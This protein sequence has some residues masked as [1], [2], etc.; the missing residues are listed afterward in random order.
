MSRAALSKAKLVDAGLKAAR[1]LL[2]VDRRHEFG[3]GYSVSLDDVNACALA[4][5]IVQQEVRKYVRGLP[6][7]RRNQRTP[8]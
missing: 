4:L 1:R 5:L 2:G 6:A 8:S 3:R 7:A